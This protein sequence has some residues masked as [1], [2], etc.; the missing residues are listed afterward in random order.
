MTLK[1]GQ[2]SEEDGERELK[3]L[4]EVR[5]SILGEGN[6][7]VLFHSSNEYFVSAKYRTRVLDDGE[8][9]FKREQLG[10]QLMGPVGM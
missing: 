9:E 3:H 4:R 6:T 10:T 5:H 1:G 7:E 2:Q 8:E